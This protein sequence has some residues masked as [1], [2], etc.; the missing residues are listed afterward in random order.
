MKMIKEEACVERLEGYIGSRGVHARLEAVFQ[1]LCGR[2]GWTRRAAC[3]SGSV[4][5]VPRIQSHSLGGLYSDY[6]FMT[7]YDTRKIPNVDHIYKGSP[8]G[9]IIIG[10]N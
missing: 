8:P 1:E 10:H 4:I 2:G 6:C 9:S 7:I 3:P 5:C